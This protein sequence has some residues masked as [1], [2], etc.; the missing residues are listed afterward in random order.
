MR[1]ITTEVFVSLS[2]ADSVGAGTI[3]DPESITIRVVDEAAGPF[4]MIEGRS[5]LGNDGGRDFA[6]CFALQTVDEINRFA[7]LCID[8]LRQAEKA[9]E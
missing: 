6:H 9:G 4:L 5:E 3:Y 8:L 1:E 2:D 7:T